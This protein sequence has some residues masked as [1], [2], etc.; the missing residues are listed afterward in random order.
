[1]TI[2]YTYHNIHWNFKHATEKDLIMYNFGVKSGREHLKPWYTRPL[3]PY[4][5]YPS[6]F[7]AS[8]NP[9]QNGKGERQKRQKATNVHCDCTNAWLQLFPTNWWRLWFNKVYICIPL[10]SRCTPLL[11]SAA[12]TRAGKTEHCKIQHGLHV[13]ANVQCCFR[14]TYPFALLQF[15]QN[16]LSCIKRTTK[17]NKANKRKQ[18]RARKRERRE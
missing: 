18:N 14:K 12:W 8:K 5:W 10:H 13:L 4:T 15:G 17:P 16:K 9:T 3:A 11:G 7:I 1:M 6:W 2:L